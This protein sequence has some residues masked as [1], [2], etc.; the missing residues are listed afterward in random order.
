MLPICKILPWDSSH[1]GVRVARVE[2]NR[3]KPE[4]VADINV[5]LNANAVDCLYFLAVPEA[6]TM[7]LAAGA[8]FR[9]VDARVT[10]DYVL[11]KNPCSESSGCVRTAVSKDIPELQRIA[12]ESHHDSR[13]YVDGN[14][15]RPA[16]DELFR[17]WIT[18]GFENKEGVV[19]VAEQDNKPVGYNSIYTSESEGV[20]S[21]I[22]IDSSYRG[23][24]LATHLMNRAEAWFRQHN[25][26]RVTVP[27]QA[28]NIPALRLYE[29]RG[30]K[31]AK[32]EPWFH[33]WL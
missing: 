25:V 13:F 8:G 9:F 31:I 3:L 18:K 32:V 2:T 33:R 6:E 17:I 5:W 16:C 12:S 22:A 1:F 29:S 4:T 23:R 20:I 28:A 19:F 10:L 27:T 15:A 14:F 26:E 24:G 11:P 30:F 7:K 21:L